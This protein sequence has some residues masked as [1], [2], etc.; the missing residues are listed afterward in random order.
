MCLLP[1]EEVQPYETHFWCTSV[2]CIVIPPDPFSACMTFCLHCHLYQAKGQRKK[3]TSP[4]VH[5]PDIVPLVLSCCT[6]P[7]AVR[8]PDASAHPC[9]FC[10]TFNNAPP[11]R[12][13]YESSTGV[14]YDPRSKLYCKDMLWH[15]HTP[16]QDPPYVPVE[17]QQHQQQQQPQDGSTTTHQNPVANTVAGGAETVAAGPQGAAAGASSI[18]VDGT[19]TSIASAVVAA[20]GDAAAAAAAAAA[21]TPTP[22]RATGGKRSAV[23]GKK[24]RI[25][26]GFKGVKLGKTG[27]GGGGGGGG[28]S[29][30]DGGGETPAREAASGGGAAALAKKRRLEDLSKWN[31]RKL[32]VCWIEEYRATGGALFAL[33]VCWARRAGMPGGWGR[34]A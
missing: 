14:Y 18:G 11:K 12:Y 34:G 27:V 32:E 33:D 3:Q 7:R 29:E 17:Q 25:A 1:S 19:G 15:R 26:F 23:G 13:F 2:V 10:C 9:Y 22:T 30:D 16:G 8:N 4:V 28:S 20:G 21:G 6:L 31:A 24:A 5:N